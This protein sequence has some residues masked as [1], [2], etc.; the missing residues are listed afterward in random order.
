MKATFKKILPLIAAVLFATS[1]S[2]DDNNES[3]VVVNNGPTTEVSNEQGTTDDIV[4]FPFS[5]RVSTGNSLSKI[6]FSGKDGTSEYTVQFDDEVDLGKKLT[7]TAVPEEGQNYS[8]VKGEL[9]LK[10]DY[11]GNYYYFE[12]NIS[13]TTNATA[14]KDG[15]IQLTGSFEGGEV[16]SGYKISQVSL[17]D[18]MNDEKVTHKFL[19]KEFNFNSTEIKILDQVAYFCI[20]VADTQ[21]KFDLTIGG[22]PETFISTTKKRFWIAV[23]V[24]T[25]VKGN[26]ISRSGITAKAGKIYKANR[27]RDV[28]LGPDFTVLWTTCNLGADEPGEYGLY[29][30]YGETTGHEAGY[31][32]YTVNYY[33]GTE[34]PLSSAHDAATAVLGAG[35]RMPTS[36]ECQTLA[37]IQSSTK[38]GDDYSFNSG[39]TFK[40]SY[41]S[42]FL[43]AAGFC[44]DN[45]LSQGGTE[46]HYWSS[47]PHVEVELSYLAYYMRFSTNASINVGEDN[48]YVGRSVRAVREMN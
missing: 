39:A 27:T 4:T 20:E 38:E 16:F 30:A 21:K 6:A 23:S 42:V 44:S 22:N 33:K 43:P 14:L 8:D 15:T 3:D 47:S 37:N 17:V 41:G 26:L 40:T 48:R 28:D 31:N 46:C 12:G 45:K 24:G 2:K 34:N 35:Y 13:A 10:K 29:Y 1:C 18:L 11:E 9:E 5:V 25:V 36:V 7:V 32:F 19:A